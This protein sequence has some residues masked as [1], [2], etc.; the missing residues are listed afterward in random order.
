M[1]EIVYLHRNGQVTRVTAEF[2]A[3]HLFPIVQYGPLYAE[4]TGEIPLELE[5]S[6]EWVDLVTAA[7]KWPEVQPH[8]EEMAL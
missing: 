8:I 5:D 7:E 3:L 4:Y 1:N 6:V 2:A